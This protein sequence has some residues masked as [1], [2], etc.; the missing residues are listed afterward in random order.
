[1]CRS[2]ANKPTTT[3]KKTLLPNIKERGI[4]R[5][6]HATS[7]KFLM[8]SMQKKNP[9]FDVFIWQIFK[10]VH[11]NLPSC[12]W[13]SENSTEFAKICL[14]VLLKA[15]RTTESSRVLSVT[16]NSHRSNYHKVICWTFVLMPFI[17][18]TVHNAVD[19]TSFTKRLGLS[20]GPYKSPKPKSFPMPEPLTWPLWRIQCSSWW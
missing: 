6:G 10:N 9:I 18:A 20:S 5:G 8:N 15:L 13:C 16:E 11:F 2:R 4:G 3:T 17:S 7:C 14:E 1:M 19:R 12:G